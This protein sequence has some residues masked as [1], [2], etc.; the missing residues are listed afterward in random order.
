MIFLPTLYFYLYLLLYPFLGFLLL[1][2]LPLYF[3]P[4]IGFLLPFLLPLY[5]PPLL[6]L[7]LLI[8]FLLQAPLIFLPPLKSWNFKSKIQVFTQYLTFQLKYLRL[9]DQ[10]IIE[11]FQLD[12]LVIIQVLVLI[13][14]PRL[15]IHLPQAMKKVM[16][17]HS[18]LL[19]L[20]EQYADFIYLFF[21]YS[22]I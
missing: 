12:L 21:D 10:K 19:N 22:I 16:V 1:F 20:S 11:G 17:L 9:I 14:L 13:I 8:V 6:F 7:N 2:L 18:T 4:F 5:L 15:I 3:P